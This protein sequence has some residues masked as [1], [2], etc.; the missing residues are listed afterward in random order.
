MA[1]KNSFV[2]FDLETHATD[3][4]PDA[5]AADTLRSL[6]HQQ[7][8]QLNGFDDEITQLRVR[9]RALEEQKAEVAKFRD[10][11][12]AFLAPI[13][14]LP[15]EILGEV[16]VQ[17]LLALRDEERSRFKKFADVFNVCGPLFRVCKRWKRIALGTP[18]L[19]TVF[20]VIPG[21]KDRVQM[22]LDKSGALP[23]QILLDPDIRN[24]FL[25]VQPILDNFHRVEEIDGFDVHLM[26]EILR[27]EC[28][29]PTPVLRVVRLTDAGRFSQDQCFRFQN[30]I[31]APAIESLELTNCICL[32][33]VFCRNLGKLHH[34]KLAEDSES[35]LDLYIPALLDIL[36]FS[37]SLRSL[38]L[39]LPRQMMAIRADISMITVPHLRLL[40]VRGRRNHILELLAV[41]DAPYLD[42]LTLAYWGERNSTSS[43]I[44]IQTFLRA[45]PPPLRSLTLSR[46]SL[47]TGND[48][49]DFISRLSHLEYLELDKCDVDVGHLMA[50]IL[51]SCLQHDNMV[52]PKLAT[53]SLIQKTFAGEVLVELVKSRAPLP[54]VPWENRCLQSVKIQ[55]GFFEDTCISGLEVISATCGSRL[56]IDWLEWL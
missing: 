14:K 26:E 46:V 44:P 32:L 7:D 8:V 6:I 56:T 47:G 20:Q 38:H 29:F 55:C 50:L 40:D 39:R 45:N 51:D 1:L 35:Q 41:L 31:Q 9:I 43:W 52:C 19:W 48:F 36:Q 27:R 53:L 18:G 13:R 16:F 37:S 15:P 21:T 11:H 24:G 4:V 49:G 28:I 3:F 22:C 17:C 12:R 54:G 33:S 23:I 30:I 5:L 25:E 10:L 34:L 42:R 2:R